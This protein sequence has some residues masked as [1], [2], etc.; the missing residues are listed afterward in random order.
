MD[1]YRPVSRLTSISKVFEKI[2]YIQL[3]KYF[4]ENRLFYIS[5]YGFREGHSTDLVSIEI[6]DSIISDLENK[7]NPIAIFMDLSI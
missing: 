3:Y 5:Q 7:K 1:N 2:V 6:T 4:D